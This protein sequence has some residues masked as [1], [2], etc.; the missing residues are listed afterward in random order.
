M[1]H[2]Y[3]H[4]PEVT[5]VLDDIP[6]LVTQVQAVDRHFTG[7]MVVQ[8]DCRL[9]RLPFVWSEARLLSRPSHARSRL[10]L[11]V[12]RPSRVDMVYSEDVLAVRLP[13]DL[14]LGDLL[15]VPERSLA[16]VNAMRAE[17]S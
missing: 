10:W 14:R 7:R 1:H 16:A 3:A 17:L 15:A 8:L 4:S 11:V 2:S 6:M 5:R 12:R 13:A 9:D